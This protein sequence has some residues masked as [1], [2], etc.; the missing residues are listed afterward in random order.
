[1]AKETIG[2]GDRFGSLTVESQ[3]DGKQ[4]FVCRC[5]CGNT[6]T[7]ARYQLRNGLIKTCSQHCPLHQNPPS[8]LKDLTGQKFGKLTVISRVLPRKGETEYN[9]HCDCGNDC[10]VK[11]SKLLKGSVISCGCVPLNRLRNDLTGQ[12]FGRLVVLSRA[13]NIGNDVAYLCQCDCG[14]KTTVRGYLLTSG[15]TVSC[16]CARKGSVHE[17]ARGVMK[18]DLLGQTFGE[19]T[20]I[21]FVKPGRWVFRCSC[22]R[23]VEMDSYNVKYGTTKSCGHVNA[24]RLKQMVADGTTGNRLGTNIPR[25]TNSMN[26]RLCAN[27]SSGATGVRVRY[28][29]HG[30]PTYQVR[31]WYHGKSVY[32][33]T[34]STMEKAVEARKEAEKKY[35]LP[36]I[37][38]DKKLQEENTK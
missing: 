20:A 28:D 12:R 23:E 10:I 18:D 30:K 38:A 19:L 36:L 1:M 4:L 14:N 3:I 2:V 33:A 15:Q 37:E 35:Y 24:N 22:G 32:T 27:N 29:N 6:K 25:I 16:G 13:E 21:R 31:L 34:F 5:D 17:K 9:C 7:V 8:Q 26:G 11:R